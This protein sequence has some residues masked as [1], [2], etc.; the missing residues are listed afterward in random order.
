MRSNVTIREP[1]PTT[2]P[3][4]LFRRGGHIYQS[5]EA[6]PS[7][8]IEEWLKNSG[9]VLHSQELMYDAVSTQRSEFGAGAKSRRP[10]P[11]RVCSTVVHVAYNAESVMMLFWHA[12]RPLVHQRLQ[13]THR[14]DLYCSWPTLFPFFILSGGDG[15]P[16]VD[17]NLYLDENSTRGRG[18]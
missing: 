17:A 7:T 9:S 6:S 3:D 4:Y 1:A 13:I 15:R 12:A 8:Y 2:T 16:A 11:L 14:Q 5:P 10:K 18:I